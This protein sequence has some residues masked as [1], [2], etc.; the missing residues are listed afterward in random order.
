MHRQELSASSAAASSGA[1]SKAQGRESVFVVSINGLAGF[2]L[3][4]CVC[5][6]WHA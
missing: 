6:V 1:A 3:K 2:D 5:E 4:P